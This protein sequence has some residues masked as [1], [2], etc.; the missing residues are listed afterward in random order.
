MEFYVVI[1]LNLGS[2]E[3]SYITCC[4]MN[5]F[6]SFPLSSVFAFCSPPPPKAG[7]YDFSPNPSANAKFS[8]SDSPEDFSDDDDDDERQ[9]KWTNMAGSEWTTYLIWYSESS[10]TYD[11]WGIRHE[12]L[13]GE[14]CAAFPPS[15]N[16]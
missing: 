9:S 7:R 10:M 2:S 4:G 13:Q 1:K 5:F 11:W 8:N 3:G 12:L 15:C 6:L 14:H 16:Q